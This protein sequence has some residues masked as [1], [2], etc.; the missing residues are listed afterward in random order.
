MV[1]AAAADRGIGEGVGADGEGGGEQAVASNDDG[2]SRIGVVDSVVTAA[3]ND[4]GGGVRVTS[5][6][7][8]RRSSSFGGS[9]G[10]PSCWSALALVE[11]KD[12]GAGGDG[13]WN[14]LSSRRG[15]KR[16]LDPGE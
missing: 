10:L 5:G 2:G 15:E 1:A 6:S 3:A 14:M 9:G 11:A 13:G 12:G 8:R 4:G 7:E 16:P